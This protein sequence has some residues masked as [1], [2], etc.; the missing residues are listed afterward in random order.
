MSMIN[1]YPQT[2]NQFTLIPNVFIDQY[3]SNSNGDFIKVYLLLLRL[4]SKGTYQISLI[5]IADYLH[6]TEADVTRAFKYWE[7]NKVIAVTYNDKELHS[8]RFLSLEDTNQSDVVNESAQEQPKANIKISTKPNYKIEEIKSFMDQNDYK[9][10][11]YITQKYLGKMLTQQDINTI[12]SFNDWLGLPFEVIELLIEYCVSNNHR[13]MNY[14][15]KVAIDWADNNINTVSKAQQRIEIFNKEYFTIM[16]SFGIGD[17]TP[18]SSE[19]NYMNK[20][21]NKYQLPLEIVQEACSRTIENTGKPNF[22]YTD[23]ILTNWH[24]NAVKTFDD[25]KKLDMI[26]NN[27]K[28]SSKD[29]ETQPKK[30]NKFINYNQRTYNFDE[31]EKRAMEMFVKETNQGGY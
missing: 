21:L 20:W 6:L 27:K 30:Q 29:K 26:H 14:I 2:I 28:N 23:S 17:R 16:K 24:K 1:I 12:I 22:P 11:I 31:L 25:I 13:N 19:I 15:E 3:I 5:D 8:I 18:A 10:L 7:N 9:Q 4:I